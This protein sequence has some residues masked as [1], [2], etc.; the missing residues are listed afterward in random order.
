MV[1]WIHTS[2]EN[3]GEREERENFLF[4][5]LPADTDTEVKNLESTEQ[6]VAVRTKS[7]WQG[8]GA[9]LTSLSLYMVIEQRHGAPTTAKVPQ[10]HDCIGICP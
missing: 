6:S 1:K 7:E 2:Q 8:P 4:C 3:E 9:I 5:F 10:A